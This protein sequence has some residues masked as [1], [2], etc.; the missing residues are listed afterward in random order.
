MSF[1]FFQPT[2]VFDGLLVGTV[3]QSITEPPHRRGNERKEIFIEEKEEN[4]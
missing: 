4:L 1:E 2:T 3:M